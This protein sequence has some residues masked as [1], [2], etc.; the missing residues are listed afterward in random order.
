[1]QRDLG[2]G[3]WGLSDSW[4]SVHIRAPIYQ[5]KFWSVFCQ[6]NL[7]HYCHIFNK[8]LLIPSNIDVAS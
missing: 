7:S 1:M 6:H 2:E 4:S 8:A 3:A 5:V